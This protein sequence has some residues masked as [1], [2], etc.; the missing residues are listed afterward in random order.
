M[1][2]FHQIGHFNVNVN[3]NENKFRIEDLAGLNY[4]LY[5]G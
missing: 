1:V 5:T 4:Y 3:K 2:F